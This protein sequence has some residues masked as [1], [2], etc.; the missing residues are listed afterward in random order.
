[1][2]LILVIIILLTF[3]SIYDKKS[4]DL[5]LKNIKNVKL[6][7]IFLCLTVI[8]LYFLLQGIYMKTILKSLN[9]KITLKK[10]IFYS[11]IEFY[12]SGITP[13]STGGQPVQLYYMTKD[14]IPLR[15]SYITLMLNTIYFKL[16]MVILGIFVLIFNN[17]YVFSNK[18]IYIFF[19][20]LGFITDIIIVIVFI[21]YLNNVLFINN[22]II[23]N[24]NII[25]KRN[26]K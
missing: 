19:F 12:F 3:N 25:I 24:N 20:V 17:S 13:S 10:G 22:I 7:Y 4:I 6:S 5:I 21:E 2:F 15:K 23:D 26:E 18:A 16:I 14:K 11:M 8:F 1:M 9:K